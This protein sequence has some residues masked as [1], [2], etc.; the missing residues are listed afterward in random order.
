MYHFFGLE[1]Q[2]FASVRVMVAGVVSVRCCQKLCNY[3]NQVHT[4]RLQDGPATDKA[5]T[6]S[7]GGRISGI[8][9]LN[10]GEVTMQDQILAKERSRNM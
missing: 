5:E 10:A 3:L 8:M 4:S 9:Y 7:D 6:I 2:L 1:W